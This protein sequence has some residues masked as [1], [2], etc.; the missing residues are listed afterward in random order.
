MTISP[1]ILR[2]LLGIAVRDA[3]R[4]GFVCDRSVGGKLP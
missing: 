2:D 4:A 3:A 1:R